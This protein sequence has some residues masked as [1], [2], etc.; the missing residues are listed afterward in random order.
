MLT[1]HRT[2]KK[3]L[4]GS[5]NLRG[6]QLTFSSLNLFSPNVLAVN[7]FVYSKAIKLLKNSSVGFHVLE[8]PDFCTLQTGTETTQPSRALVSCP[9]GALVG[10]ACS[11]LKPGLFLGVLLYYLLLFLIISVLMKI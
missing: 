1:S 7:S 3:F 8:I 10:S 5:G 9:L 11:T 6:Q 2:G 4:I